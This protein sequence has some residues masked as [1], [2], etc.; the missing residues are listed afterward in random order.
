MTTA[1]ASEQSEGSAGT[2][3]R[4]GGIGGRQRRSTL[5]MRQIVVSY[6]LKTHQPMPCPVDRAR[7]QRTNQF[8]REWTFSWP[9]LPRSVDFHLATGDYLKRA[10]SDDIRPAIDTVCP[11]GTRVAR[12][13]ARLKL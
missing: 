9:G 11:R 1:A 8:D 6:A 7:R 5:C 2:G 4:V 3:R 10:T 12:S 13:K